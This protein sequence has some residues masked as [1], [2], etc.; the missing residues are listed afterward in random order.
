MRPLANL[1][2]LSAALAA[3]SAAAPAL[4]KPIAYQDGTTAVFDYGPHMRE[5][6]VFY[7]PD[8]NS[9][10]GA[11]WVRVVLNDY[12]TDTHAHGAGTSFPDNLDIAYFRANLLAQRW[13][14]TGAQ[15]NVYLWGG[16]GTANSNT[17]AGPDTVPNAG[18]QLDAE[19]LRYYTSLKTDWHSTFGFTWGMS[20]LQ[21]GV[22]PYL[23]GYHGLATW[24]VLQGHSMN[25]TLH[26]ETG[27]AG[28]V[29]LFWRGTWL[30]AGADFKGKP[31]AQLMFNF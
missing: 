16:L 30:Q 6:Q 19:T 22:A 24:L 5:A 2:L 4:A 3:A 1:L 13:N 26:R 27:G 10:I 18:F 28:L 17:R 8:V 7:A 15:A 20:T 21:V 14:F 9:S 11:G 31:V 29:R 25:G 23:H 12:S